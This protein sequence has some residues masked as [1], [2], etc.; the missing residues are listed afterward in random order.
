MR[1]WLA[2]LQ[3]GGISISCCEVL[4]RG[5]SN[6]RSCPCGADM[7]GRPPRSRAKLRPMLVAPSRSRL[8]R[9]PSRP[10]L[11]PQSGWH[12]VAPSAPQRG[13]RGQG[14]ARGHLGHDPRRTPRTRPTSDTSDTTHVGHFGHDPRRTPLT[15]PT[16]GTSDT[17]RVGHLGH[18]PR[19]I[20]R[21][22]LTSDTS[23]TTHVGH[24]GNNPRRTPRTRPTSDTSDTTHV[25]HFGHL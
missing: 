2:S 21:T 16:L 13:G 3:N 19:R 15:R 23:D 1:R 24:L 14:R 17:A 25:G 12:F 9:C 6:S 7:S 20:L 22:R 8:K 4:H 11:G 10:D 18:D 5:P